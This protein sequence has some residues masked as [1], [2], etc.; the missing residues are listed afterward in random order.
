MSTAAERLEALAAK[1]ERRRAD[2]WAE[3]SWR[4]FTDGLESQP[5]MWPAGIRMR[6]TVRPYEGVPEAARAALPGGASALEGEDYPATSSPRGT[7]CAV[8]DGDLLGVKPAEFEIVTWST[9]RVSPREIYESRS[10][11]FYE[12]RPAAEDDEPASMPESS[13]DFEAERESAGRPA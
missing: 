1:I 7:V 9:E 5:E 6:K 8:V 2:S 13:D 12:G 3:L 10:V 11:A 4:R